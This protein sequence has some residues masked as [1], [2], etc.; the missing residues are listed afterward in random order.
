VSLSPWDTRLAGR[1]VGLAAVIGAVTV[2]IVA[3]T[4]EGAPWAR[5]LGMC[6]AL[7]PVAATVAVLA[8]IRLADGRG[9]LRALAA[10][11]ADPIRAALGAIVGGM[12]IALAGPALAASRFA[13]L[14]SLFPRPVAARVWVL[15]GDG[16]MREITQGL[17]LARDGTLSVLDDAAPPSGALPA[18]AAGA[19]LLALTIGAVAAPFWAAVPAAASRRAFVALAVVL[20]AI[21][22]FQSVAAGR[23]GPGLLVAPPLLLVADALA[24]LISSRRRIARRP[25][26]GA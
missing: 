22:A 18:G 20:A 1:A 8:T 3:T 9:E 10:L 16:A 21:L 7:A 5:R 13:D 24:S 25:A 2:V 6:A 4:D 19:A 12:A 26:A 15:D 11:G 17:L 14:S 23:A